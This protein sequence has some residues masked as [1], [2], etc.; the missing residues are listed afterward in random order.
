VTDQRAVECSDARARLDT[1]R[2]RGASESLLTW[3]NGPNVVWVGGE[4]VTIDDGTPVAVNSFGP[5]VLLQ[6][7]DEFHGVCADGET[8]DVR[9]ISLSGS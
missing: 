1:A 8:A 4:T 9:V 2:D 5:P 6:R 7:G 3:N